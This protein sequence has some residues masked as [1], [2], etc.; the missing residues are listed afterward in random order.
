MKVE[1]LSNLK[2][3]ERFEAAFNR[4]HEFLRSNV[5][6]YND[7]FLALL[8][9]GAKRHAMIN[10]YKEDLTKYAKLRNVLVHEK[11][12]VGYYIAEPNLQIV[13]HIEKIAN[14]FN[15]PNYALS[16]ATKKVIFFNS[17]DSI[18]HVIQ[19]LKE[20]SYAQYPVYHNNECIGLLTNAHI[21]R[22]FAEHVENNILD[23]REI[24][25]KDIIENVSKHP[26]QF[27]PKNIN[28]FEAEE[29]F[30]VAHKNKSELEAIIITENGKQNES[31]LGLITAW[32]LIEID[33]TID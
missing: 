21:V 27:V 1:T 18:L 12:E 11:V 29:I 24:K 31:P 8:N 17:E 5:K 16:I 22:W 25:V 28:I 9:E 10:T 14:I 20:H 7:K 33:Y 32:D 3:S 2:L 15:K 19:G 6:I 4:I 23:L 13:E 26:V 30:E